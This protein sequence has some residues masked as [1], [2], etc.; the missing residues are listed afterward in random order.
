METMMAKLSKQ[1]K[2]QAVQMLDQMQAVQAALNTEVREMRAEIKEEMGV[3]RTEMREL[4]TELGEL[5]EE[6]EEGDVAQW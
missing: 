3:M 2:E 1:L 4:R 6:N 5:K